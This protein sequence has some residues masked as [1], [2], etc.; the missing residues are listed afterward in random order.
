MLRRLHKKSDLPAGDGGDFIFDNRQSMDAHTLPEQSYEMKERNR[1]IFEMI[2]EL[3]IDQKAAVM[4]YYVDGLS[5]KETADI[6]ECPVNTVKTRLGYARTKLKAAAEQRKKKG[7]SVYSFGFI[8]FVGIMIRLAM[9]SVTA[10]GAQAAG[11]FTSV[12]GA[13]GMAQAGGTVTVAT[14]SAAAA[15]FATAAT[16]VT[17]AVVAGAG[18]NGN[19]GRG[20]RG[21]EQ[22]G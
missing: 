5:V 19:C 12:T 13:A 16:T 21:D 3:P 6:L 10:T 8:P 11:V 7:I 4:C 20:R 9:N 17:A 15:V 2:Q 18:C 14:K 22:T 1:I